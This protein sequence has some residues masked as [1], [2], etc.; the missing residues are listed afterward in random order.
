[1][2]NSRKDLLGQDFTILGFMDK[3]YYHR[4]ATAGVPLAVI[5]RREATCSHTIVQ[6]PGSVFMLPD[7]TADW[8][9]SHS[10]H[11]QAGLGFYAGTQLRYKVPGA[12]A[13]VVFGSLCVAS[14]TPQPPLTNM[15]QRSL[16]R[17][18]DMIVH[19]I[20][21]RA[22]AVRATDRQKMSSLLTEIT[23][24]LNV[25]NVEEL[26]FDILRQTYPDA[27]VSM[28]ER[29][30]D[31]ILLHGQSDVPYKEFEVYLWE[32]AVTID[33]EILQF[34]HVPTAERPSI[35]TLRAIAVKR[36]AVPHGYLVVETSDMKHIFD[37]IDAAFVQSCAL[38]W[39]N[40]VQSS[41][42]RELMEAKT[43]FLRN[44][45]H[46]MRTPIHA[47]LCTCE[48]LIEESR[49]QNKML[50]SDLFMGPSI[51]DRNHLDSFSTAF[52]TLATIDASGRS[53]LNT[54][55]SLLNFDRLDTLVPVPQ[56]ISIASLEQE[57]VEQA[58][59]AESVSESDVTFV[60]NNELP[61]DLELLDT[62]LDLLKQCLGAVVQNAM[63]F[64]SR[65]TVTL[66]TSA[67]PDYAQLV[68]DVIDTG[69]GIAKVDQKRVFEPFEKANSSGHGAG[70]GLPV[71]A[72]IAA[73]LEGTLDLVSSSPSG[74]HFRLTLNHPSFAC[75]LANVQRRLRSPGLR[76]TYCMPVPQQLATF[77]LTYVAR[78]LEQLGFVSAKANHAL[79]AVVEASD[80]K[81]LVEM[82]LRN[83]QD[84]QVVVCICRTDEEVRDVGE[85]A[86]RVGIRGRVVTCQPPAYRA[87][88]LRVIDEVLDVYERL[89]LSTHWVAAMNETPYGDR[90]AT[91][92]AIVHHGKRDF[93]S[94]HVL[95]VDDNKTNL[96]ILC[97]NSKRRKHR[98]TTAMDGLQAV[99]RYK[100][101]APAKN[102]DNSNVPISLVLVRRLFWCSVGCKG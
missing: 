73:A 61:S 39:C 54:V 25:D 58:L 2:L 51:R 28:Q 37:D 77:P 52:E 88:L 96:D 42:L 80:K 21:E 9:F 47:I 68:F 22:R 36:S 59:T 16:L 35:Q 8:R 31:T 20:V 87:R 17:L 69:V 79:V 67:T 24:K 3:E 11:V 46:E 64:T 102:S 72:R 98:Y 10:P 6:K 94:L 44:L 23:P 57:V 33:R 76:A 27:Q 93:A 78:G 63:S 65:G 89:G 40:I 82:M 92:G 81:E 53:L 86:A 62:D 71:A 97:M 83:V 19:A 7:M 74:S 56:M 4:I 13:E 100:A 101:C 90:P 84:W 1:M 55:N 49:N 95:I 15:Q 18:S 75:C 60:C 45:S 30:D 43:R 50:S 14:S 26:L 5:P 70:L 34:N 41:K 66:R 32:D 12:S 99:D 85:M 29:Q 38:I 48:L 91:D